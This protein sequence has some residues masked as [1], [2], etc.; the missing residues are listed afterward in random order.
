M[1]QASESDR[2][3]SG[4]TRPSAVGPTDDAGAGVAD[5]QHQ[6]VVGRRVDLAAAVAS[7]NSTASTGLPVFGSGACRR[8]RR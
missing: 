4:F 3:T 6:G 5:G 2:I 7:R 8:G 1:K